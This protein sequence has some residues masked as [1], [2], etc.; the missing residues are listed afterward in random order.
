ML[1][2]QFG[3][4]RLHLLVSKEVP[5][6]KTDYRHSFFQDINGTPP[7]M[8]RLQISSRHIFLSLYELMLV[9]P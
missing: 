1:F 4:C 2:D 8:Y 7:A 3:S 9:F 6:N 5:L